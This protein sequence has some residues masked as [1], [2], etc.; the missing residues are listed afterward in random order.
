MKDYI[1]FYKGWAASE[2]T[3]K[4]FAADK[5]TKLSKAYSWIRKAR[6]ELR[7]SGTGFMPIEVEQT[8]EMGSRYIL[9]TT[10]SGVKIEIPL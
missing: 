6:E 4:D 1:S 7:S 3:I 2:K 10:S 8:G 5:N 9:I